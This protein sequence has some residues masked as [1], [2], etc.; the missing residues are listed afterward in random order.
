MFT[1]ENLYVQYLLSCLPPPLWSLSLCV[2]SVFVSSCIKYAKV[3]SVLLSWHE[4][5]LL[6]WAVA[7]CSAIH[8]SKYFPLLLCVS[9]YIATLYGPRSLLGRRHRLSVCLPH[10]YLFPYIQNETCSSI[11]VVR[12][13]TIQ[14]YIQYN[15]TTVHTVEQYDGKQYIEYNNT[16]VL[17]LQKCDST[18][19][20]TVQQYLQ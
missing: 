13:T 8:L 9:G 14:Q 12:V 10:P 7:L 5:V 11:V 1:I 4:Y 15:S 2:C 6:C 17:R 18:P 16:T 19:V 3:F 20:H